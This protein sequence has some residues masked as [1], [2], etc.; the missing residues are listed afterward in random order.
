MTNASLRLLVLAGVLM[1]VVAALTGAT[2][3]RAAGQQLSVLEA[4]DDYRQETWRWQR[5]M[6]VRRTPTSYSERSRENAAYRRWVLGLWRERAARAERLARRPPNKNAWLC[7][8]RHEALHAG[9]WQAR[10]GNGYFGGLQMSMTFQRTLAP[11]LLRRKGT[12]DVWTPIEQMWVAE[13]AV[14]RGYGFTPWP[15]TAARCG[16]L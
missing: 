10:T 8:H 14:R 4:I 13:R 11:E 1:L 16:L 2:D 12:A 5:L 6:Q 15:N 3:S 7:I 9:G